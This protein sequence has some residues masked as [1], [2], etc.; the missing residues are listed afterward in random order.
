MKVINKS[1]LFLL[2]IIIVLSGCGSD[3][4]DV[5]ED[6]YST[7]EYEITLNYSDHDPPTG[8]RTKFIKDFWFP[9]IEKETDG[10]VKINEIYGGGLLSAGEAL[11]GVRDGVADMGLIYPDNYPTRMYSYEL[12]KLFPEAPADFEGI[13]KIFDEAMKE[14]PEL[15]ESL[16]RNNQKPLLIT[17]G[18]PIVFGSTK[19]MDSLADLKGDDWRASSRWYLEAIKNIG[20]NPVSVPFEDVYMSLET[21]VIDGVMTNYDGFHMMNFYESASNIILG[22]RLWWSA[23]FIH[24]INLDMWE[25][26]PIDIQEGI[27]RATETAQNEFANVYQDELENAIAI[28]EQAGATVKIADDED[29]DIFIDEQLF[30]RLRETWIK[31]AKKNHGIEDAERYVEEL[32]RIMSDALRNQSGT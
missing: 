5:T 11:D 26:L 21:G 25:R 28:Q 19:E 31:E 22:T 8:M 14:L 29:I 23:P 7:D 6:G 15:N 1:M 24:T 10:K 17:T 32:E 27:L 3:L 18:L 13:Y 12:F 16:A 20:A 30:E 9:E 2:M 4:Q